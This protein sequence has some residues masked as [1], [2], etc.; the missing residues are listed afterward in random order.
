MSRQSFQLSAAAEQIQQLLIARIV[1]EI[2]SQDAAISFS[3]FMQM[4]LYTPQLG[5]YQNPLYTFGEKGDFITA[6]EMGDLFAACLAKSL[7]GAVAD[8]S[9]PRMNLLELGAGSGKLACDLLMHLKKQGIVVERYNILEPSANLQKQQQQLF[10]QHGLS[11]CVEWLDSLPQDFCGHIIAN[12]VVDAIP[13]EIIRKV[14]QRWHYVGVG[15]DNEQFC[16]RVL[17]EVEAEKIPEDLKPIND[18][19]EGYTTEIRPLVPAWLAGLSSS[20]R[21]GTITLF[22]YGYPRAEL[23][24]SQRHQGSLQ[25]FSRHSKTSDPLRLIGLQ[26]ITAHVD[27]T[28]IAESAVACG[29]QVNGFTTQSGYLLANGV[30]EL[31]ESES[32]ITTYQCSQQIQKLIAPGQ[33]GEVV[34][35]ILLAKGNCISLPSG[36]QLQ[37]HLYRL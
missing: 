2:R 27:F 29:L 18:F 12:E 15:I 1:K 19:C 16:W 37:D 9:K 4:A 6:P 28:Q 11:G 26:D 36:F 8:K 5:Y 20:L 3:K 13:C 23:Y 7:M 10:D 25:C 22:D 34:K 30:L 21:E 31:L 24:H 33:M 32:N 35:V 17:D 14:G